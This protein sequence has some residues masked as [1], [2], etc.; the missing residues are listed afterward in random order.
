MIIKNGLVFDTDFH[1]RKRDLYIDKSLKFINKPLEND[2]DIIDA[3]GL[4][5]IPGL[6]DIHI[7]GAVGHD[8]CDADGEGLTKIASYLHSYGITSF[9]PTSMTLP[10]KDLNNIFSSTSKVC[11]SKNHSRIVGINMEGP[12]LSSEKKG[13]Q[14]EAFLSNPSIE[15]F[16]RLNQSI[17]PKIKLVTIA[18]ELENSYEFIKELSKV[19]NISLGHSTASYDIAKTA[20]NCGANHVTHIFNAMMPFNHREPGIVGAASDSEH[21]MVEIICDGI[22]IHPSVV[23]NVFNMFGDDRVILISDNMRATGMNDG[24]YELGGQTVFKKGCYATLEDGTLAGSVTNLFTCM[25]NAISFGIPIES[26]IKAVTI[27]PA[28]SIGMEDLIGTF[29]P[30]AYADILMLDRELN[31][32]KII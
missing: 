29:K 31:I 22:H 21:V 6:I 27:N 3:E 28:K 24:K 19:T 8:F 13:A 15:M 14:K 26:V 4:Y 12:F 25:K 32:V 1:F 30:G 11:E 7:H 2:L 23:R 9:C 18:P 5:I 10:E 20:F 17:P 16:N